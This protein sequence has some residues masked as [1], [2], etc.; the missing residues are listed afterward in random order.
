MVIARV[1][2]TVDL[3]V[4]IMA[5]KVGD[6]TVIEPQLCLEVSGEGFV[7]AVQVAVRA[8]ACS[9]AGAASYG[10]R[11]HCVGR[12]FNDFDY[13]FASCVRDLHVVEAVAVFDV[14]IVE[15]RAVTCLPG[16]CTD[17]AELSSATA[18]RCE[19]GTIVTWKGAHGHLPG[20]VVTAFFQF[21]HSFT[22][23][24]SLPALFLCHFDQPIGV[25]VFGTLSSC[26]KFVIA[27]DADLGVASPAAGVLHA[28]G[29]IH[30]NS[31]RFDPF[32]TAL[33]WAI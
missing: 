6:G 19:H 5:V 12:V 3:Y 33:C 31:G 21:D 25:F 18:T 23:V 11:W 1:T 22:V 15:P 14:A 13:I 4:G 29:R 8:M 32:P 20:H 24:A 7:C 10:R 30:A 27:H 17:H 16:S 9:C 2:Y 26:V 28:V